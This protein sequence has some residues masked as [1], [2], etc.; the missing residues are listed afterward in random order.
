MNLRAF[1][2]VFLCLGWASVRAQEKAGEQA[3]G[4]KIRREFSDYYQEITYHD[5]KNRVATIRSYYYDGVIFAE[6]HYV[7]RPTYENFSAN[8]AQ[9]VRHGSSRIWHRNGQVYVIGDY[10]DNQLNGPFQVFYESGALKRREFYRLGRVRKSTCFTEDGEKKTCEPFYQDAS[11]PGG[12]NEMVAYLRSRL[13]DSTRTATQPQYFYAQLT[14][15]EIGQVVRVQ[16][17]RLTPSLPSRIYQALRDM[18]NWKPA[19]VDG[20]PFMTQQ[21]VS[22]VFSRGVVSLYNPVTPRPWQGPTRRPRSNT[23]RSMDG[24]SSGSGIW[25]PMGSQGVIR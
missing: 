7:V 25:S 11:F 5:S 23:M 12:K 1:L 13:N 4:R 15:N 24:F 20:T 14:I 17:A 18:P 8:D 21:L 6:D 10:K 9:L 16:P 2:L 22:L 3:Q 19:S